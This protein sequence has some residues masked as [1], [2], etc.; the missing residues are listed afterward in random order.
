M[1]IYG[2]DGT[3]HLAI[4]CMLSK[5]KPQSSVMGRFDLRLCQYPQKL[6]NHPL[7]SIQGISRFPDP[8]TAFQMWQKEWREKLMKRLMNG[9]IPQH[10]P[11]SADVVSIEDRQSFLLRRVI[12][13]SQPDRKNELLLALPQIHQV[14]YR[15]WWLCMDTRHPG[16][17]P[18]PLPSLLVMPTISALILHPE[19]GRSYNRQP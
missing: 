11:I 1:L 10:V 9:E 12:Y 19:A 5:S 17:R 3:E 13:Q 4:H 14:L 7:I 15:C 16:E 6:I 2:R 8:L 18:I